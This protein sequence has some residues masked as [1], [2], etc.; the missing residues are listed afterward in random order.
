M[1]AQTED[2]YVLAV[3]T[4]RLREIARSYS[5]TAKTNALMNAAREID[6]LRD[7]LAVAAGAQS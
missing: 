5:D 7:A 4:A 2:A 3:D 1:S 6:R